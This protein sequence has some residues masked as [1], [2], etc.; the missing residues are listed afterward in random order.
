[1]TSALRQAYLSLATSFTA[2]GEKEV[3]WNL[4]ILK[5]NDRSFYLTSKSWGSGFLFVKRNMSKWAILLCRCEVIS[6]LQILECVL[7]WEEICLLVQISEGWSRGQGF[8]TLELSWSWI[9]AE[10]C[11]LEKG[12]DPGRLVPGTAHRGWIQSVGLQVATIGSSGVSV[13]VFPAVIF[14]PGGQLGWEAA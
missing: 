12:W 3:T 9:W 1:M 11:H 8:N 13:L 4:R 5:C 2:F 14:K 10:F 6:S 7:N